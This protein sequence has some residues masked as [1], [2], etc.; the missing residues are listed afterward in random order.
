MITALYASLA[1]LLILLLTAKVI[2]LR[3]KYQVSLGD[4]GHADLAG[5][6]RA[7]GNAIE[8]IP[9]T[10]LLMLLLEMM[11]ASTLLIHL[12][13]LSLLIGRLIHANG[14]TRTV[15]GQRILGMQITLFTIFVLVL[16]NIIYFFMSVF[17]LQ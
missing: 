10:L 17:T 16:L 12:A 7:H 9:L 2:K 8:Y 6:I 15:I 11:D 13:G 1:V 5:A 4:G 14:L 3:R